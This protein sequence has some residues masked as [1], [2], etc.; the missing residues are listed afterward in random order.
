M[1]VTAY[2]GLGSNLDDPAQQVALAMQRLAHL[3]K[4]AL[5]ASSRL[6]RNPPMGPQDQPE[7]VNAVVKL[8]TELDAHGLLAALQ[9]IERD[10]GRQRMKLRWGPRII[11]LDL[12]LYGTHIINS[13]TLTVPHGGLAE[14]AFVLLPM[15]EIEP[16]LDLPLLGPIA[17][18]LQAID[19]R[20]VVPL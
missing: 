16:Q 17:N 12:L 1:T 14:R 6:Y 9:A 2:V 13:P 18:L 19:C 7:Y 5:L 11:D 8:S 15:A 10:S 4:S 20:A 3:E